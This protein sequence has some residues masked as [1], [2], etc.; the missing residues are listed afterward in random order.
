LNYLT[1]EAALKQHL[2]KHNLSARW[3]TWKRWFSRGD[4]Y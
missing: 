1:N 4:E 2:S 3:K